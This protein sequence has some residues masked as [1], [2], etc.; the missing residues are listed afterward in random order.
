M[1]IRCLYDKLVPVS[2]LSPHPKNPSTH[3]S[4]QIQRLAKILEYQG[5]RYP[6]KVSKQSGYI[7]S[8][9][10]RLEAAKLNG[11]ES[12]P[13]NYQDY[14]TT[15]QETADLI[16]DN[17]ISEWSTIDLSKIH[18]ELSDLGPMNIDV[19][20]LK[21]FAVEPADKEPK[22]KKKKICPNCSHQW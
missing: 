2:E 8:G 11:W 19:L 12:V 6:I 3:P 15:D 22:E 14:E 10:G 7:T 1:I 4:D 21:D 17:A 5:W 16:A 13:V 9:H 18:L 20:G